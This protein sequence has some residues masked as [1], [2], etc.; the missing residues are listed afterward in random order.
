MY[1]THSNPL[2]I[3]STKILI[4]EDDE[5]II[6]LVSYNLEAAGFSV[7]V[8][9]SGD[10]ALTAIVQRQPSLVILDWMLPGLSGLEI[11]RLIRARKDTRDLPIIML[12]A[13]TEIK[14]RLLAF[15]AGA[16]DYVVKPF[17]SA[18]L[19]GRVNALLRR[20]YPRKDAG[21]LQIGDLLLDTQAH[22]V[23]IGNRDI[24]L[25]PTEYH[26]L[27][28]FMRRAGRVL[29]RAQLIE[30]VWGNTTDV[31]ER[32]VDVHVGRLRTTLVQAG[33]RDMIRT[34][35]GA[36]YLLDDKEPDD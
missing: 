5:A 35:R 36:G 7:A 4:V 34:V 12:T 20:A 6:A 26:L 8:V 17:S 27:E 15:E 22:N 29:S 19:V 16:D 3:M 23:T 18:E 9:R 24:S 32:T 25:G 2:P 33:V 13:R 21:I 14:D 28:V 30:H 1:A 10:K 11:C 31:S